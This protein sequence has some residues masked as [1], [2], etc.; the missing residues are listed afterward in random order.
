MSEEKANES[1]VPLTPE[2]RIELLENKVDKNRV[3]LLFFALIL[4]V[5]ISATV[6]ACV[7]YSFGGVSSN[8][9]DASDDIANTIA[10]QKE[11]LEQYDLRL[12]E[13]NAHIKSFENR[14]DNNA[15][16]TIQQVLIEQEQAKQRFME[17]VRAA[18]YDLAHMVPGSRSWLELYTEQLEVAT[19]KSAMREKQ[20]KELKTAKPIDKSDSFFGDDF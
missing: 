17:T 7:I 10:G 6:T 18:V 16:S 19:T 11:L 5:T 4:T 12:A 14:I 13:L 2:Q 8:N 15:N 1:E 9:S 3:F 20:L